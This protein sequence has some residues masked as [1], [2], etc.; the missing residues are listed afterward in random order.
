M[1]YRLAAFA[2]VAVAL[3]AQSYTGSIGGRVTDATGL[4]VPDVVITVT[5]TRTNTVTRTASNSTGD[6]LVSFLQPGTYRAGFSKEGFKQQMRGD[7]ALQLNQHLRMDASLEVGAVTEKVEVS[8]AAEH[9]NYTSPEIGHVVDEQQLLNVPLVA[10]N[11]RGRSPLLLAKLLPGV[12]S[13]SANNSNINNFS[14]GGGR[15]VTNEIL[16]DG[17]PTTNPSEQ[18]Y[19]LTPSTDAIQEFKVLTP[20]FSAEW[21]HT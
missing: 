3:S 13:T 15:P 7:V 2:F 1:W 21:D 12:T 9:V 16:V 8:A 19:T 4:A 10:G 6:Y 18:N 17:L 5:E 14:F 20:P 11:S